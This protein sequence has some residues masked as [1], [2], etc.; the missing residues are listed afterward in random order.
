MQVPKVIISLTSIPD[1][2]HCER[3]DGIKSCIDSLLNQEYDNYEI[4]FNIPYKYNLSHEEYKVPD[5]LKESDKLKIFRTDDLGPPTKSVPT[6]ERIT[7]PETIIIIVDDDLVY[8]HEMIIEHVR[9]QGENDYVYGYDGIGIYDHREPPFPG[10]DIRNHYVV[11]VFKYTRTKIIQH[12]KSV[13]YKR[14]Y[15]K[16]DF[17][18]EFLGKTKSDDIMFSAYCNFHEIPMMVSP[19]AKEPELVDLEEWKEKGGVKTFPVVKHT[20]AEMETGCNDPRAE[21]RFYQ[22]QEWI[23]QRIV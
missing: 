19:Y 17:F 4:H 15:I 13:S 7:D 21:E 16:E 22:P 12:Y 1:R 5:W 10:D 3:E 20:A 8:H 23:D 9:M 14:R 11:S 18:T 6:F 2:L